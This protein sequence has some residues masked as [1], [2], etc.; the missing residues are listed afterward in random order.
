MTS[1]VF[2]TPEELKNCICSQEE[3]D[4]AVRYGHR[5]NV[6]SIDGKAIAYFYK[7]KTYLTEITLNT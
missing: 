3:L 7:G 1:N 5:V 2:I 4:E 6:K